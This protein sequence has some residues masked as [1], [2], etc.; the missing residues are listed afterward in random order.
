M[1]LHPSTLVF[2]DTFSGDPVEFAGPLRAAAGECGLAAAEDDVAKW[3]TW[4]E[5][6]SCLW[7][8]IAGMEGSPLVRVDHCVG[9]RGPPSGTV[10]K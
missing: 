10:H 2:F 8:V 6:A 9:S 3:T 5:V 7:P 1:E 4:M